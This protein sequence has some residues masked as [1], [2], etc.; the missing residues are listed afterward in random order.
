MDDEN[1][2]GAG[3]Q[4]A[5]RPDGS[6]HRAVIRGAGFI[7]LG[8]LGAA[9]EPATVFIF[10]ALYGVSTFGL[11]LYL[12][13][14]VQLL[15]T[16]TDFGM[17]SC[18]QRFVPSQKNREDEHRVVRIAL[19]VSSVTSISAAIFIAAIAGVIAPYI[20]TDNLPVSLVASVIRVYAFALPLWC[21]IDVS[22]AAIRAQR[23]FGPEIRVR[24]FYEQGL[25][26]A[27]GVLFYA[28]GW[29]TIYGLVVSHLLALSVAAFFAVRLL[30]RYYDFKALLPQRD[31]AARAL[32]REMRRYAGLIVF[33]NFGKRLHQFL[34]VFFLNFL[35]PG[36]AG[37]ASVAVYSVARKTVSML[38]VVRQTFEY[39]LAPFASEQH[40]KADIEALRN[41]YAF[42]TRMILAMFIPIATA[43]MVLGGD[44]L[45]LLKPEFLT[46]LTALIIMTFG[47]GFEAASGPSAAIVEMIGSYRI[48]LINALTGNLVSAILC[49]V[50]IPEFGVT[51]GAIAASVG[52]NVTAYMALAEVYYLH[53][54]LPFDRKVLRPLGVTILGSGLFALG[55]IEADA[56]APVVKISLAV[57]GLVLLYYIVLNLGLSAQDRT[58]ID[59]NG[60]L[61][62]FWLTPRSPTLQ[63]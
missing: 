18:L 62:R 47:R 61:R 32:G 7:F 52:L 37:A 45:G 35:L 39:V 6:D 51:G 9:I 5:K 57:A 2:T 42:A 48:P 26:L 28:V 36:A 22:T 40:G 63:G 30:T 44:L 19:I 33:N 54:L 50:L 34:P 41:V 27:S 49:I 24:I 10:A 16:L 1:D 53:H 23:V 55:V 21:F 59:P 17:T 12:W 46:G 15:S 29:A 60:K 11:F 3:S 8:R 38:T 56:L 58:A 13:A 43:L 25:R 20:Q 14:A 31:A 4:A